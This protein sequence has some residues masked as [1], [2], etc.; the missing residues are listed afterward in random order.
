M[1]KNKDENA[2]EIAQLCQANLSQ[3]QTHLLNDENISHYLLDIT[4]VMVT[5]TSPTSPVSKNQSTAGIAYCCSLF[6]HI[7]NRFVRFFHPKTED[8]EVD[9]ESNVEVEESE[10][11][12]PEELKRVRMRRRKINS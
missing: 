4:A 5:C 8:E 3:I 7:L 12:E 10:D 2:Y 9:A 11:E 1:G 6:L